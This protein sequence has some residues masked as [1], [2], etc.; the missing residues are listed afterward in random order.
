MVVKVAWMQKD[1]SEPITF[2][3]DCVHQ[4]RG[5]GR[6]CTRG[7]QGERDAEGARAEDFGEDR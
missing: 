3:C 2:L 5:P 7:P 1:G 4:F 6:G